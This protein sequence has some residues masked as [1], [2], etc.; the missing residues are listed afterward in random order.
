M[1]FLI[2]PVKLASELWDL[3]FFHMG[4][5]PNSVGV[6]IFNITYT[7]W[8]VNFCLYITKHMYLFLFRFFLFPCEVWRLKPNSNMLI[9]T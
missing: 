9:E 1:D 6:S 2:H 4:L 5:L 8:S 7:I 3:H